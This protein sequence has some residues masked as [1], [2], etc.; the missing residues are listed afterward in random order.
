MFDWSE[1]FGRRKRKIKKDGLKSKISKFEKYLRQR[2]LVKRVMP[3]RKKSEKKITI[4]F[5]IMH[6][7]GSI[8]SVS[9]DKD[10]AHVVLRFVSSPQMIEEYRD[11]LEKVS[12]D[13]AV[14]IGSN[15]T[16]HFE[17][18]FKGSS[19]TSKAIST[20]KK[21]LDKVEDENL[22]ITPLEFGGK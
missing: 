22:L 18:R 12:R 1:V 2:D 17:A 4:D 7:S 19:S 8:S 15:R 3:F 16:I 11:N 21:V 5:E 14:Y 6:S 10:R 9:F 20:V 13:S